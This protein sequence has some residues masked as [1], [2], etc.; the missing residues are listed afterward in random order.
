MKTEIVITRD[1]AID[2]LEDNFRLLDIGLSS[3]LTR[4]SEASIIFWTLD[5]I[6][7]YERDFYVKACA[8]AY[9][10]KI[11]TNCEEE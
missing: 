1:Y 4:C 5:L 7:E 11:P 9:F 2:L 6:T 3:S 10:S 8:C